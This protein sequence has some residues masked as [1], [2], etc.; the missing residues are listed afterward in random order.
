MS[1]LLHFNPTELRGL[2]IFQALPEETLVEL[3]KAGR[4]ES[5]PAGHVL[6]REGEK[7]DFLHIP[8]TGMIELFSRYGDRETTLA[9]ISPGASYSLGAVLLIEPYLESSRPL[10]PSDI[11]SFPMETVQR[12]LQTDPLF[13]KALYTELGRTARGYLR[14]LKNLKLRTSLERLAAWI[15]KTDIINGG[16]GRFRI[17]FDKRTLASHLGMTP[18][19]LS[20]TFA[21]LKKQDIEIKGRDIHII[22]RAA[23][24]Q[25]AQ[26]THMID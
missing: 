9:M 4:L 22:R 5:V 10:V 26:L 17:G 1:G 12:L 20:R 25:I 14:S 23:L 6:T 13:A 19:N 11:A 7:P 8:V 21:A 24:E 3:S 16:K 2:R 15:L 18:E